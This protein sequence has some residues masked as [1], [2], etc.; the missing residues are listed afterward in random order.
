MLC[1]KINRTVRIIFFF[2]VL[3]I[4]NTCSSDDNIVAEFGNEKITL[5]EFKAAYLKL[6]KQPDFFDSKEKREKFLDD[7]IAFRLLANKAK[8]LNLHSDERIKY[9]IEAY[10]NKALR[11]AHYDHVI[12]PKIQ[13]N[14]KEIEDTYI[15]TQEERRISHLFLKSKR[16]ADSV[17]QLL[18]SGKT[19]ESLASQ[20]FDDDSLKNNGGDLGWITWDQFEYDLAKASFTLPIDKYSKP[21]KSSFGYHIIKVTDYKKKPLITRN[22]Y[23]VHR[24]RAKSLLEYK[25]GDKI[26]S[27]YVNNLVK[28]ADVVMYPKIYYL[29]QSG[30]T[31][32]LKRVPTQFDQMTEFQL[33]EN[34]VKQIETNLW[35][36]RDEIIVTINGKDL[37]VGEFIGG[38]HYI[39][40]ENIYSNFNTTFKLIV[41]DFLLTEEAEVFQL[42]EK[43]EV[44]N[45]IKLFGEYLTQLKFRRKLIRE[46]KVTEEEI[47]KVYKLNNEK[48]KKANKKDVLPIIK[49]QLLNKKRRETV[50]NI[51]KELKQKLSIKTN[52]NII[53]EYYDS[54]L[55]KNS[56][57][58]DEQI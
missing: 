39:P 56:N 22:E 3:L 20:I 14:E 16:D 10:K 48:Y 52:P 9:K 33:S 8:K 15:F 24:K 42:D 47:E 2:S 21:I 12:K 34:E 1:K 7:L 35:D 23:L 45:K 18:E 29:V 5:E 30:L 51:I 19:F 41:R 36:S 54:I 28:S 53:H 17:Y 31:K 25:I 38:L 55:N 32:N 6:L 11:E 37:S 49:N 40:Y 13:F 44:N 58:T 46:Q 27:E 50:P 26:A 4:F 43:S 57:K